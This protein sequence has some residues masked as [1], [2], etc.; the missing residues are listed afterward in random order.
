MVRRKQLAWLGAFLVVLAV[1]TPLVAQVPENL[2]NGMRWRL[3]G[4]FRGGRVEAVAGIPGNPNLYY[5]GA[6]AGGVWKTTDGG[7]RWQPIFDREPVQSIGAIA[8]DPS[9]PQTIYVG[10]GE[11]ALRDDIAFGDGVY[12]STDGGRT[13][14]N[15]GLRDSR[16]IAKILVDPRHP[17]TVFVAAL[18]HAFGPNAERGVFRSNDGGQSW[19][20]V[21][22]VDENTGAGDLVFDPNNPSILYAAMFQ[23]RRQPWVMIS[24][25]PASGLFKSTDGGTTWTHLQGN[26]LP[27]G[28]LG[29]IGVAVSKADSNRVYAMIEAQKNAL[30]RSDDGGQTWRMMNDDSLWVRP[31]Y[32]NDVFADPQNADRVYLLDLG[33]YRSDDGGRTFRPL[34]VPHSDEHD[35]WID[36]TNP[37]RMIEANDG[38]ATVSTDGGES[39]TPQDNQPTAQFYHVVTDNE[40]DY[41]LYGSQQD[42]GTVAIRSRTDSGS[43]GDKDW[44]SVG[45]GESGFILP[46]PRDPEIVYAGDHNGHFTR[47]DGHTGQVQIISP[48]LGA[49]AHVPAELEHR[50]NWTSPMALSPHDPNVLYIG[51]EVLFKSTTGGM[52]W[53]VISPDLTRNDKSKQQ[54][55][56][57]PLTPDNSS[58]EYYDTLF[59][60][61]ESPVQAGLIWA[62]SD[63]GLVHL[64]RDDGRTWTDVTP[65]QLPAWTRVNLIEPSRYDAGAAYLVGDRHM[66]D[67]P[68]P[69][70]YKTTD[71]GATWTEIIQGLP[72]TVSVESVRQDTM[73]R[74]LLFAGTEDGIY[75]SFD[76][77]GNWQSLQLNLPHV[78]VYDM[79][80]HGDD[81]AIATHGRAFWMLDDITPL[82]QATAAIAPDP[83][84]L[85]NPAPAYRERGGGG[86]GGGGRGNSGANPPAGAILDYYLASAPSEPI[87][88]QILDSR[89][90]VVRQFTSGGSR[91]ERGAPRA[92]LP[93]RA[94][95]NRFVW[96]LREVGPAA[97]PGLVIVE[98]QRGEGPFVMPGAYQVKLTAAGKDYTAPLEVRIDPRVHVTQE[99]LQKQFEFALEVRDRINQVHGAVN[100]ILA[101]RKA[102]E[103]ARQGASDSASQAI[104]GVEQKM[105]AIEEQLTQVHS[106]TLGAS[107]VYPIMLDAQYAD[108]ANTAESADTAPTAQTYH[109][110]ESY[111]RK[112]EA[113]LAQWK[114]LQ[115]QISSLE[116]R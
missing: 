9:D 56:P 76:D 3:V 55:S 51:A 15:I 92:G 115:G 85:Y 62:G 12:K 41:R 57:A 29:R 34:P 66:L 116:R 32:G 45:G 84:H 111:E 63:D 39:W 1:A 100:Q 102:L 33:L 25:G 16:H 77:G 52:S 58:A 8:L 17:Q 72:P 65:K 54:S 112:R 93:A 36:P 113:L 101:A 28:I 42:S 68:R 64:T 90:Q 80:V 82:R 108:L 43:I 2:Y 98:L 97:V 70:I 6:V 91:A 11:P 31:W 18:G 74:G 30:Y 99:D 109:V 50:F 19:Q 71:F 48:W 44:H 24:G 94:G 60:V 61:A 67:D 86:F 49:R 107:L 20:K 103:A 75:V 13:W 87:T 95:M 73:R 35:M 106:T 37:R 23:A 38:G 105:D 104:D 7:I 110:F 53:T 69:L 46:D 89:G 96:D 26:G 114:A 79:T 78:P 47:Y 59:A 22:Y 88:L 40:F 27:S 21:L 5:F 14:T 10:T 81:L 4:P 83:V